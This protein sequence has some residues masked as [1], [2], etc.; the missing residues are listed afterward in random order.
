[1]RIRVL[2]FTVML[3]FVV[4]GLLSVFAPKKAEAIPA[5]SRQTG[6]SCS[7]CHSAF[8]KLNQTGQNFRT[9][10]F[11]F[12]EDKE[13][14]DVQD[15]K[16]VPLSV[17]AEVEAEFEKEKGGQQKSNM[18]LDEVELQAGLPIGKNGGFSA[19]S[20]VSFPGE[21]GKSVEVKQAFGQVN[22]LIGEKGHGLLNLK[23]GQFDISLPFLSNVQR[24]IK[25]RYYSQDNLGIIGSTKGGNVEF[26]NTAIELNGQIVGKDPN[27][28]THRYAIGLYNPTT[29]QDGNQL[30]NPGIYVSYAVNFLENFNLGAIYKRDVV[31]KPTP[32]IPNA[33]KALGKWGIAADAKIG[34][35]IATLAYFRSESIDSKSL[36]NVMG[37]VLVMPTKQWVLGARM[38][39][40]NQEATK[41]GTRTSAMVRY[42]ISPSVYFQGEYR[43]EEAFGNGVD[44]VNDRG[45]LVALY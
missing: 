34:P 23:V 19:F 13:W 10:G 18:H 8:P 32:D 36:D 45:F 11:R 14:N 27:D 17:E 15:L 25:Q 9:N 40:L 42:Y 6:K 7:T 5:F 21:A 2:V 29:I 39:F 16:H 33:K 24:V 38:D 22:D 30:G 26:F 41:S 37:E 28:L 20:I 1:M 4:S 35:V 44:S 3:S 12:P 43:L 31:D